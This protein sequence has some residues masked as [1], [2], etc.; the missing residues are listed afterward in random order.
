MINEFSFKKFS[1]DKYILISAISGIVLFLIMFGIAYV[2][3][4]PL[5]KNIILHTNI[6][7]EIDWFGSFSDLVLVLVLFFII[8]IL[9]NFLAYILYF[10][11]RFLSYVVAFSTMFIMFVGL[12]GFW[13]VSLLN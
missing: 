10:R 9:N 13:M 5:E 6:N 8:F 11:N 12:V 2:Q 4:F 3:L 1:K 7:K